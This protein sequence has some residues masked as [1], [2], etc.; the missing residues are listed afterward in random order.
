M[1]LA[2]DADD[3]LWHNEPIFNFTQDKVAALLADWAS[4]EDLGD[5]LNTIERRNLRLFGYGTKGFT[6]SLIETALEISGG[7]LPGRVVQQILDHGKEMIEH[8]V[9]L[10]PG[11]RETLEGLRG[12]HPLLLITKGDLFH[13]EW[14]IARSGLADFFDIIE[15]VSEKDPGS[16]RRLLE[17]H[18][19]APERFTMVGNSVKSD[20]LPVVAVG[21]NAIHIPYE[22][23]W[24][25][26]RV[27]HRGA[28][29]EGFFEVPS[30]SDV[31]AML[32]HIAGLGWESPDAKGTTEG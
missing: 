28:E 11:V 13:Q 2:F 18:D 14:K 17:L 25:L 1:H 30:I 21:G 31:P 5:R 20:I 24:E 7:E 19:I 22:S 3:T 9:E 10:L 29:E 6:L 16:Y 15:I 26:D 23:S 12:R 27:D 32:Q 4:A 8:P